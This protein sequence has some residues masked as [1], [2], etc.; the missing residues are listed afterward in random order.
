MASIYR[1]ERPI[2]DLNLVVRGAAT[3][4][5]LIR[6]RSPGSRPCAS[7]SA[8]IRRGRPTGSSKRSRAQATGSISTALASD[9]RTSE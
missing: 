9:P 2:V 8:G 6:T 4:L 7:A 1:S 5:S 3:I